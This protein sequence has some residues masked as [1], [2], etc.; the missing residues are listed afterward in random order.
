MT[1][2]TNMTCNKIDRISKHNLG[3]YSGIEKTVS[4][5]VNLIFSQKQMSYSS[6]Q[7]QMERK[8]ECDKQ[9]STLDIY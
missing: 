7:N 1:T 8:Y 9:T 4:S 6:L 3:C 2:T 5:F